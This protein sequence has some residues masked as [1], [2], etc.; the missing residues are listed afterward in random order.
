[1]DKILLCIIGAGGHGRVAADIA[2]LR[3]YEVIF[4]DDKTTRNVAGKTGD[5]LQYLDVAVYFVAI[6]NSHVRK[7]FLA[8]LHSKAANVVSLIHPSAVVCEDVAIGPGTIIMAGAVINTGTVLGEGVIVNTCASVDHDCR[9]DNYVHVA[10]GAHVCGTVHVGEHT[11][12]GA[13]ATVINN[14]HICENC[15]IGA[16][17]TV[18]RSI[19][20][21]GTYVGTPARLI[22]E[23]ECD[24]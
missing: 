11:W 19:E 7:Q 13:G 4:L 16:G 15:M 12:V 6:G 10:V 20:K 1:M 9:I 14:M 17:A 23:K 21:K 24:G 5:Y 8:E 18:I 2:R 3:G 22:L